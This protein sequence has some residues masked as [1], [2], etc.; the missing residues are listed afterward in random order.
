MLRQYDKVKIVKDLPDE[1]IT[2]GQIGYIIEVWD[3]N[4]FEVEISDPSNGFTLFLGTL[5]REILEVV[6]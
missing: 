4:H 6:G 1:G 5:H 2:K 3:E